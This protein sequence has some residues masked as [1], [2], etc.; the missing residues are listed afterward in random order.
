MNLAVSQSGA[1]FPAASPAARDGGG[2]GLATPRSSRDDGQRPEGASRR[3]LG[4]ASRRSLGDASRRSLGGSS[5]GGGGGRR[6]RG[7]ASRRGSHAAVGPAGPSSSSRGSLDTAL[8]MMGGKDSKGRVS[9]DGTPAV[10]LMATP[11]KEEEAGPSN[12]AGTAWALPLEAG[13]ALPITPVIPAVLPGAEG[14]AE[15]EA[16]CGGVEGAVNNAGE[17]IEEEDEKG[18]SE[19]EVAES[20]REGEEEGEGE[21][22]LGPPCWHEVVIK[23]MLHP[24]SGR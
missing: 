12:T 14:P 4:D 18:D 2:G 22:D 16:E 6:R 10:L 11:S 5:A 24:V 1:S 19:A 23:T 7:A 3:S 13:L 8:I 20:E 17:E 9:V 21:E 15:V